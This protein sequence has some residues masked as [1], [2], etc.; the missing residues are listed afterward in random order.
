MRDNN[1]DYVERCWQSNAYSKTIL[2]IVV[3]ILNYVFYLIVKS[4]SC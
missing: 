3:I 2:K 4:Q 1:Q